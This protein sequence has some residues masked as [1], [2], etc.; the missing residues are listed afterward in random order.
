MESDSNLDAIFAALADAKRR[1][2]LTFLSE[3]PRS[4]GEIAANFDLTLGAI[5]KNIKILESARLI[6]KS[7]RGRFVYCHMNFDIWREVARF[8][9]MQARFWGSRLDELEGYIETMSNPGG[10][11]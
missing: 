3:G 5:S 11:R 6:H 10:H 4:V 1:S 9:A 8:I 2:I 7:K